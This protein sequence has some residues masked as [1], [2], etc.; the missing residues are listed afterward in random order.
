MVPNS[1][2]WILLSLLCR[3]IC[4]VASI[5]MSKPFTGSS[6]RAAPIA[7]TVFCLS[8]LRS[9]ANLSTGRALGMTLIFLS[10]SNPL[11]RQHCASHLLTATKWI[12]AEVYS[13]VCPIT[14]GDI[15]DNKVV[16]V[17]ESEYMWPGVECCDWFKLI[18]V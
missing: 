13:P 3:T 12:S 2:S 10:E 4:F 1:N 8:P 9:Y 18:T 15:P 16:T 6:R 7:T 14:D 17:D 11:L 5:R